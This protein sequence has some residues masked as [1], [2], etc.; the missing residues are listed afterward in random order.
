M[1]R[2]GL[3]EWW[4]DVDNRRLA[5]PRL[6]KEIFNLKIHLNGMKHKSSLAVKTLANL[7]QRYDNEFNKIVDDLGERI[8]ANLDRLEA[9]HGQDQRTPE[10]PAEIIWHTE[11]M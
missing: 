6:S 2:Q 1:A 11:G 4:A 9:E 7:E 3:R 5:L 10:L 8:Q